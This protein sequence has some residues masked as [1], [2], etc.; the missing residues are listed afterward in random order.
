MKY[1]FNSKIACC[2]CFCLSNVY[3][4][5]TSSESLSLENWDSDIRWLWNGWDMKKDYKGGEIG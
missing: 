4:T 3:F 2:F 1:T 5:F